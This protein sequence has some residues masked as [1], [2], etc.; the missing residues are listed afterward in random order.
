MELKDLIARMTPDIHANLRR[1]VELGKWSD[2][3][4]L[5][6][7]QKEH[8]LEAVI[9][10]EALHTEEIDRV[11]YLDRGHKEPADECDDPQPLKLP[12]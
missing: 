9:A 6:P 1:A 11:G 2:G 8:S 5:T 7:Q 10:Y 3:T 4:P 12:E